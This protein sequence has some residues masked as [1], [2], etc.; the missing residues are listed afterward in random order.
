[1]S[2][3]FWYIPPKAC[4]PLRF[5]SAIF[6]FLGVMT[7]ITG[8][9]SYRGGI[10]ATGAEAVGIGVAFLICS[11]AIGSITFFIRTR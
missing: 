4:K 10:P 11:F 3:S 5:I 8:E 9:F 2:N 6:L 1:M 7:L